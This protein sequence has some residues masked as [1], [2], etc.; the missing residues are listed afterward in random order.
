MR[1]GE[2][3]ALTYG[4]FTDVIRVTKT[5]KKQRV[6]QGGSTITVG[7]PKT[8]E[9]IREL[10]FKGK[11]K[12]AFQKHKAER[13]IEKLQHGEGRIHDTD[14]VFTAARGN[15]RLDSSV[16]RYHMGRACKTLCIP[17]RSPHAFRHTYITKLAQSGAVL[18][19]IVKDLA[20]HS[21]IKTTM[22]YFHAEMDHKELSITV[23]D[24]F[25]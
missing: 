7:K 21:N 18:P 20:G 9:S 3:L 15:N 2:A 24:A 22:R 14:P 4:D 23:V 12:E 5:I 8:K 16:V 1:I 10:P 19:V 25:L 11:L 13:Q 6:K 17:H